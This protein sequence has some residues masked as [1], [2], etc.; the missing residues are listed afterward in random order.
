[1]PNKFKPETKLTFGY[2]INATHMHRE[3]M[4]GN[5]TIC[6][7]TAQYWA[8]SEEAKA[9][10]EAKTLAIATGSVSA[11]AER[12]RTIDGVNKVVASATY[13]RPKHV[14]DLIEV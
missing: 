4:D 6:D 13:R 2:C 8:S 11:H 5:Y 3:V 7:H 14:S 1:M 10:E 9:Y 12:I